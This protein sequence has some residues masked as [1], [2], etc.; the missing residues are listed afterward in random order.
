LFI[1]IILYLKKVGRKRLGGKREG[2]G[3]GNYY[4]E[5]KEET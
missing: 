2:E 1:I 5:S 4:L 3:G